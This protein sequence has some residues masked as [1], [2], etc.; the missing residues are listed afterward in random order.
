M[1]LNFNSLFFLLIFFTSCQKEVEL[2]L[3][4]S[5]NKLVVNCLFSPDDVFKVNVSYSLKINQS[6]V[7]FID[8]AKIKLFK[9]NQYLETLVNDS[10][11]WYHSI[12]KPEINSLYSI[13]VTYLNDFVYAESY[14]PDT[15]Y[16]DGFFK[17]DLINL[18]STYFNQTNFNFKIV[19][20]LTKNRYY[21]VLE[22]YF[23]QI[24]EDYNCIDN[25][26][27][28][29]ESEIDYNP[30]SIIF[31]NNSFETDTTDFIVKKCV[32]NTLTNPITTPLPTP[33]AKQTFF[34]TLSKEYFNFIK[35]G[36]KHKYNQNTQDKVTDPLDIVFIGDPVEMYSNINNGYGIF[37]GYTIRNLTLNYKE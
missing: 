1:K 16:V 13:E 28:L 19:D 12:I 34:K 25:P 15:A 9:N 24:Q 29:S 36:I 2:K 5:K 30:K 21:Q 3:D 11:G 10:L 6:D 4:E 31:S 17:E 32:E 8:N 22:G 14:V 35:T 7:D 23:F 18:N 37:A 27:I 33:A 20:D 26:I